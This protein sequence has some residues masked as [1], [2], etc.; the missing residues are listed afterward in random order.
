[1]TSKALQA[2]E[3]ACAVLEKAAD[4]PGELPARYLNDFS[5]HFDPAWSASK[6][7]SAAFVAKL[8]QSKVS[9]TCFTSDCALPVCVTRTVSWARH[10]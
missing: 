9:G 3:K 7:S 2:L 5:K 8:A 6:Q 4:E 10:V 1:M